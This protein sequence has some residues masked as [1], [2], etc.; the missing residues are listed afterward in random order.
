MILIV[1]AKLRCQPG[2]AAT[3]HRQQRQGGRFGG[4]ILPVTGFFGARR[5]GTSAGTAP[6]GPNRRPPDANGLICVGKGSIKLALLADG[7]RTD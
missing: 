4:I 1:Q 7:F 2:P 3:A 5:P 6:V